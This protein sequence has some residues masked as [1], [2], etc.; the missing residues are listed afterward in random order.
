MAAHEGGDVERERQIGRWIAH[1]FPGDQ[2]VGDLSLDFD[3]RDVEVAADGL[4]H[5]AVRQYQ[6]EQLATHLAHALLDALGGLRLGFHRVD[7]VILQI[8][9]D[10]LSLLGREGEGKR[11]SLDLARPVAFQR[12]FHLG[13]DVGDSQSWHLIRG[14]CSIWNV[15]GAPSPTPRCVT[16]LEI[17]RTRE[18][19]PAGQTLGQTANFR[20]T[21][22]EIHVSPGF[23]AN[24]L[25]SASEL[26]SDAQGGALCHAVSLKKKVFPPKWHRTPNRK[27]ASIAGLKTNCINSTCA[28]VPPS[29]RAGSTSSRSLARKSTARQ[30]RPPRS[31]PASTYSLCAAPPD[32]SPRTWRPASLF[33]SP[34]RNAPS[35]SR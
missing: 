13:G 1:Q 9:A 16:V 35:P 19:I 15:E 17:R 27:W 2:R 3:A 29:M 28:T 8:P 31:H 25:A 34:L 33:L 10:I 22:S 7:P 30:P 12:C 32:A 20:Q 23:A 11:P 14:E 18:R 5:V 21:A 6:L 24:V 26:R 4:P